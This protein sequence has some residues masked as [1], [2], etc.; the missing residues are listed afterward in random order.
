MAAQ[1]SGEQTAIRGVGYFVIEHS[2][3]PVREAALCQSQCVS[4]FNIVRT[5]R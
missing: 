4:T 5:G 2:Q 3:G 1:R